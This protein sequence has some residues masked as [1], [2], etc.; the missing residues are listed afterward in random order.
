MTPFDAVLVGY[1]V[2][3]APRSVEVRTAERFVRRACLTDPHNNSSVGFRVLAGHPLPSAPSK[4]MD[5]LHRGN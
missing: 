2:M 5:T 1:G 3:A 4:I